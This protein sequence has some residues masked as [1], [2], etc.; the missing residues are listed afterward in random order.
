VRLLVMDPRSGAVLDRRFDDLP[1]L[2]DPGDVLVVND[3]ATLPGS[4]AAVTERFEPVEVRLVAPTDDETRWRAVLFGIGDWRERTEDR[5]APPSLPLGA[6]LRFRG[7]LAATVVAV[8]PISARLIELAF[9]SDARRMWASIYDSGTPVQYAHLD[10]GLDLWSV[11]T[12]YA[13]RPWA[14]EMPS[15]GRALSWA[16][17]SALRARGVTI[18]RLTHAAGLSATGDP[19]LDAALPLP[20]RYDIPAETVSAIEGARGRVIAVGTTVVRA[21]EGNVATHGALV[22]GTGETSLVL[23]PHHRL[24]VVDGIISGMHDPSESHYQLLRA[25]T[26]EGILR[27]GFDRAVGLG[28]RAHEFGDATLITPRWTS[29]SATA[30][31][32][33]RMVAS[34]RP[35][36]PRARAP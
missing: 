10:H 2:L 26:D 7:G 29:S 28:Y 1:L 27:D 4:L 3:A 30:S 20:E 13:A 31:R 24:R 23:G 11:Q 21:I 34:T 6:T 33:P 12:V 14:A 16:L 8:S 22:A 18:A 35:W 36:W 17:L 25:F 9:A 19:E 32:A 15:A 5:A